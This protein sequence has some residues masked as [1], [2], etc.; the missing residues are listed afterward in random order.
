[1]R[2]AYDFQDPIVGADTLDGSHAVTFTTN[3]FERVARTTIVYAHAALRSASCLVE[4]GQNPKGRA[5]R[6]RRLIGDAVLYSAVWRLRRG[7]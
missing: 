2:V 7:A 6:F 1:M 5:I 3:Y 4:A